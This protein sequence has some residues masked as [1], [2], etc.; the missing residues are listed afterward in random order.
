MPVEFLTD[1]QAAAFGRFLARPLQ[2][3]LDRAFLLDEADFVLLGRRRGDHDR[4]GFCLYLT[5]LRFL[6]TVVKQYLLRRTTRFDNP[7]R[8][9]GWSPLP[10]MTKPRRHDHDGQGAS[11]AVR[12]QLHRLGHMVSR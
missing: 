12:Q 8:A 3:E 9:A 1:E 2:A 7:V 10:R 4:P 11:G 6:G 5:T